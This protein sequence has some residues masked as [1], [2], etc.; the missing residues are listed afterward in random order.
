MNTK[1]IKK[2]NSKK[3]ILLEEV[4]QITKCLVIGSKNCSVSRFIK[5]LNKSSESSQS[6]NEATLRLDKTNFVFWGGNQI[7]KKSSLKQYLGY[8]GAQILFFL[9]N[10]A[11]I[12]VRE[13][14]DIQIK[15]IIP[16][17]MF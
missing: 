7:F 8:H 11:D 1:V 10:E 2:R 15:L 14:P 9:I 4:E 16:V 13:S 17:L 3:R 5:S 12:E 6:E